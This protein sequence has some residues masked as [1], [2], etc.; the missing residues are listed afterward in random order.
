MARDGSDR[1]RQPHVF[2]PS[3]SVHEARRRRIGWPAPASVGIL[4]ALVLSP[5]CASRRPLQASDCPQE[6]V[7]EFHDAVNKIDNGKCDEAR[8]SV[9]RLTGDHPNSCVHLEG[10]FSDPY[11]AHYLQ[12]KYYLRCGKKERIERYAEKARTEFEKELGSGLI[13]RN[14]EW[15]PTLDKD[16]AEARADDTQPPFLKID[17][18]ETVE[19]RFKTADDRDYEEA[20]VRVKGVA[21]DEGGVKSVTINGQTIAFTPSSSKKGEYVFSGEVPIEVGKGRPSLTVVVRDQHDNELPETH[22]VEDLPGLDLGAGAESIDAIIVGVDFYDDS[23]RDANGNCESRF[24]SDCANP[25]EFICHKL[26]R[27]TAAVAD[28]EHMRDFL[29]KR[30]V[31]ERNIH[32]LASRSAT[33]MGAT[34]PRVMAELKKLKE[35]RGEGRKIIF[36]FAGHGV[37]SKKESNLLLLSDTLPM[38][39]ADAPADTSTK[40]EATALGVR[41]ITAL[42]NDTT[43]TERYV[44][45]DAC[46]TPRLG[47]D[48]LA[49]GE[50]PGF[51]V[52]DGTR[53][54]P[55]V[56]PPDDD[57]DRGVVVFYATR[58]KRVSVEWSREGAGYFTYFL[59]QGLRRNLPLSRLWPYVQ[60]HVREQSSRDLCPEGA[61]YK[62]CRYM[63]LPVMMLPKS[64]REDLAL[65]DSTFVLGGPAGTP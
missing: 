51:D 64:I 43:F 29:L 31:P 11:F 46:R 56:V 47:R 12:G 55:G 16:L 48:G 22:E 21:A 62:D 24:R 19:T 5:S 50:V 41:Q 63:Q 49:E 8:A 25:D 28:A 4:L 27:L 35:I 7:R 58:E 13:L 65:Q 9:D 17:S 36:Y 26:P 57:D 30:G 33:D 3:G 59:I 38:E 40:L 61:S 18:I 42:L 32:F 14:G 52:S 60:A 34:R 20:I 15:K 10:S 6:I 2:L 45:V 44:I 54:I 53:R 37:L 23:Y 39:C 1:A